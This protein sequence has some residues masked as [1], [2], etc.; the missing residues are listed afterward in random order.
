MLRSVIATLVVASALLAPSIAESRD[1]YPECDKPARSCAAI[2]KVHR[3]C[4]TWACVK[5]VKAAR[6]KR[7]RREARRMRS[8]LTYV[9]ASWYGPGFYGNTTGCGQTLE[10]WTF[11]VAHKT[12]PCGTR[13][14]LCAARCAIVPV[15]DR[16]PYSGNRVFDLTAPVR[17][18]IG[19]LPLG[20]VGFKLAR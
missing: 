10:T 5:R 15:I 1:R 6:A 8:N 13:V 3:Q 9:A 2:K 4:N 14:V 18:T 20:P 16:G 11:G 17:D 19:A 12:L 7:E